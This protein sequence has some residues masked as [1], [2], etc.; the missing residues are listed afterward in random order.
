MFTLWYTFLGIREY[1]KTVLLLGSEKTEERIP[2]QETETGNLNLV[3]SQV[4]TQNRN[5][6]T[7][8]GPDKIFSK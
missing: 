8:T 5:I 1:A 7:E 6:S 3:I 4:F 2:R